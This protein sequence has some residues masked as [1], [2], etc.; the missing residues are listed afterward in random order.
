[1]GSLM[2]FLLLSVLAISLANPIPEPL[3]Q[4]EDLSV[5][6]YHMPPAPVIYQNLT[7]MTFSPTTFTLISGPNEAVLVDSPATTAQ[8]DE[9]A[10]WIA[11]TIPGKALKAVYITHGHAD[12]FF[13]ARSIQRLFPNVKVIAT[14]DTVAHM[15]QQ[16]TPEVL[17]FFWNSLFPGQ[18]D[19][20]Y[21]AAEPLPADGVFYIDNH[22]LQAIEVGQG[23]TYNS[24][25]LHVPDLDLIISGDVVEG[26]CHQVF[27]EDNTPELRAMWLQSLDKVAAL[28]PRWIVP[29]HTQ[30]N[31]GYNGPRHIAETKG[32]IKAYEEELAKAQSWQELE[33]AMMRR[34][35]DRVGDFIL[36]LSCQVPF[37][38][39]F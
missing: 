31:S 6:I 15:I 17:Q 35:P 7:N 32:Y 33:S 23:D 2:T 34:F 12:H 16:Y 4:H 5:H 18:L 25:V 1:M 10:A 9:L 24:T 38:A 19:Q 29:G 21:I 8:G 14:A 26:N 28:Q 22:R 3:W 11:S 20:D 30:P 27:Q 13:S 36:R 39:E 37:D